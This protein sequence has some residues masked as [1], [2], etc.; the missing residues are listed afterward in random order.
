MGD[1]V[2][3]SATIFST[4][5]TMPNATSTLRE[6]GLRA[7]IVGSLPLE[8][9]TVNA[10]TCLKTRIVGRFGT[11]ATRPD[12][13]MNAAW[14]MLTI[15]VRTNAHSRLTNTDGTISQTRS[16]ILPKDVKNQKLKGPQIWTKGFW[17]LGRPL[18]P[19]C[20]AS[21]AAPR[22]LAATLLARQIGRSRRPY[23]PA[24]IS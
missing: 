9:A 20:L 23:T 4:G 16:E 18:R 24:S 13:L 1:F 17:C 19:S 21:D 11:P 2:A 12:A 6:C 14:R 5:V 15:K 7:S 8:G 22:G 10:A 3:P